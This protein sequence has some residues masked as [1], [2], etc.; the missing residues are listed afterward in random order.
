MAR[1]AHP[2]G[3]DQVPVAAGVQRVELST[4]VESV[5]QRHVGRHG[6]NATA[7]WDCVERGRSPAGEGFGPLQLAALVEHVSQPARPLPR[8][9]GTAVTGGG[10]WRSGTFQRLPKS[11]SRLRK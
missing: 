11:R 5:R 6:A 7:R 1:A 3:R 8:R 10:S 9:A 2:G 4:P